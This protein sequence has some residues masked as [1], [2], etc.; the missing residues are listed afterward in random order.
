MDESTYKI[1]WATAGVGLFGSGFAVMS[2][3][4]AG[5]TPWLAV[6]PGL[7][8]LL[9]LYVFLAA[10]TPSMFFRY[11]GKAKVLSHRKTVTGMKAVL[12]MY[13]NRAQQLRRG[14]AN[15]NA[16]M[17]REWTLSLANLA[18]K[19]WGAH[20]VTLLGIDP[21][22]APGDQ[23]RAVTENLQE[24]MRRTGSEPGSH[25][26]WN[27]KSDWHIYITKI[28]PGPMKDV[29]RMVNGEE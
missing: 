12:S 18:S 15:D 1:I 7:L 27:E 20:E 16:L 4:L 24:L 11:P 14:N 10:L 26:K 23:L 17:I 21:G 8:A 2:S 22:R 28:F 25:F 6:F 3:V 13:L 9:G 19:G 29:N 5:N